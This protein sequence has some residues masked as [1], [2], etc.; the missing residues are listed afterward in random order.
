MQ[1]E[2]CWVSSEKKNRL[3]QL[4]RKIVVAHSLSVPVV[5]SGIIVNQEQVPA[6]LHSTEPTEPVVIPE[7]AIWLEDADEKIVPHAIWAVKHG[8]QRPVL[9]PDDTDPVMRLLH[10]IHTLV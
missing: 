7:P 1:I 2:K 6:P 3:L 9:V 10:V 5:L 4:I 8:Y